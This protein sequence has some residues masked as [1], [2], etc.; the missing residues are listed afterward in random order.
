[1]RQGK[2]WWNQFED[3]LMVRCIKKT[4]RL[5]LIQ[6]LT[7]GWKMTTLMVTTTMAR[8]VMAT[9][10]TKTPTSSR[11]IWGEEIHYFYDTINTIFIHK[12]GL[13]TSFRTLLFSCEKKN[14][15]NMWVESVLTQVIGWVVWLYGRSWEW[16]PQQKI[17]V[18]ERKLGTFWARHKE[19][20]G[21]TPR[22]A[23]F[24]PWFCKYNCMTPY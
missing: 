6:H 23:K 20:K 17:F 14:T 8:R 2:L 24:K 9:M 10:A 18:Y 13:A 5:E 7:V 3:D 16:T 1:M 19:Y 21:K 4:P 12:Y 15:W 11:K 22:L